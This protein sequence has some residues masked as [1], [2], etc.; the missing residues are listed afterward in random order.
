MNPRLKN[1][2]PAP[3]KRLYGTLAANL[4]AAVISASRFRHRQVYPETLRYWREL[5]DVARQSIADDALAGSHPIAIA[6]DRLES[7]LNDRAGRA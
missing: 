1:K 7:E 2:S 3:T 5:V 4:D 6:A